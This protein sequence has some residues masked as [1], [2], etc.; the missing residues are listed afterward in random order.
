MLKTPLNINIIKYQNRDKS[1]FMDTDTGFFTEST[2]LLDELLDLIPKYTTKDIIE[3]IRNKY[4]VEDITNYLD[5]LGKLHR[6]QTLFIDKFSPLYEDRKKNIRKSGIPN[7]FLN[8]AHACNL[9]CIY[10]FGHGGN[11]G[12]KR[13]I[14]TVEM[15]KRCV[16]YWYDLL[17]EEEQELTVTF[18]G[19]EPLLNKSVVKFV[20]DYINEKVK[21]KRILFNLTTNGTILD[22]ELFEFLMKNKINP[23]ISIDGDAFIQDTNRPFA[24]GKGSYDVIASNI[25]E[26]SKVF[27]HLKAR[28]T[29]TRE[30][31]PYFKKT[32]EHLWKMGFNDVSYAFVA[33]EDNKL[34]LSKTDLDVL[35]PQISAL[36]EITYKNILNNRHK[37]LGN[38]F[39]VVIKI[40]KGQINR[41]CDFQSVSSVKFS[42]T[43]EIYQCHRML[44][45]PE[46]R[47]GCIEDGI[48]WEYFISPKMKLFS[49]K[50]CEKCWV[51]AFC[52]GGCAHENYIYNKNFNEPYEIKCRETKFIVEEGFK[53]YTDLFIQAPEYIESVLGNL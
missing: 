35:F 8:I 39:D 38:I 7:L 40:H 36:C 9:R 52:S 32:V 31:V 33:L 21:N 4:S 13:E 20:V 42:P 22:K 26:M 16:D 11:Y 46:L 5:E 44:D 37:I 1:F 27:S 17:D 24:S 10:C 12:G 50:N 25:K 23:L 30:N 53:F 28:I 45:I 18:F 19:G 49:S 47:V 34:S 41:L 51:R 48:N 2:E 15:A 29:L 43:G 14:M 3:R 6:D